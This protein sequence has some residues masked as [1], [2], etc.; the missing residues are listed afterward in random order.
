MTDCI[1]DGNDHFHPIGNVCVSLKGDVPPKYTSGSSE[2]A[3]LVEHINKSLREF[4]K[5]MQDEGGDYYHSS[6][7]RLRHA[8]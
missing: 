7:Q 1:P 4:G 2:A 5:S 6:M 3:I 8:S